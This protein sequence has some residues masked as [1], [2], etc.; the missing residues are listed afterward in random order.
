MAFTLSRTLAQPYDETVDAVRAALGEQGFGILTE[1]DLSA[2]LKE[3]L[4]A[5]IAPQG[6][7]STNDMTP[8]INHLRRVPC[9]GQTASTRRTTRRWRSCP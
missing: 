7:L 9:A 3:K 2:T 1:I 8:V 4:D 6:I 5:D